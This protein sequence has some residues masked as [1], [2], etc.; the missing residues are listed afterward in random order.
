MTN[1]ENFI[2]S[3]PINRNRDLTTD[4]SCVIHARMSDHSQTNSMKTRF[5]LTLIP[6]LMLAPTTGRCALLAYESFNYAPGTDVLTLQ[7]TS[8]GFTDCGVSTRSLTSTCGL[9]GIWPLGQS[10]NSFSTPGD[11]RKSTSF[12]AAA[13]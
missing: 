6:L 8:M 10:A 9:S 3:P 4:C 1:F 7:N 5:F 13:G 11:N 2:T 12:R